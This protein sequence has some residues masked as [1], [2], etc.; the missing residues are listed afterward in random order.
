[1][2]LFY[3]IAKAVALLFGILMVLSIGVVV[4]NPLAIR[5][6]RL[7]KKGRG[8][9]R[10]SLMGYLRG[11]IHV[12]AFTQAIQGKEDLLIGLVA[13][14]AEEFGEFGRQKL[15]YIFETTGAHHL[16][17]KAIRQLSQSRSSQKRQRIATFLPY[18]AI[19]QVIIP[20]GSSASEI[21]IS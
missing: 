5:R 21:T 11:E 2:T 19:N 3:L 12:S 13:Q 14:L 10:E 16:V 1:M 20:P 6:E 18:I 17:Q 4:F 8:A 7:A 15:I 9:L